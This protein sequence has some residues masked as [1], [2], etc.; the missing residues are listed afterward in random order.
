MTSAQQAA[1]LRSLLPTG[2]GSA[3]LRA[4]IAEDIRSRSVF[5]ARTTSAVYLSGVAEV[6]AKMANGDMDLATARWN[7]MQLLD[8]LGYTPEGGFPE[9]EE[10][11]PGPV[12]PAVAGSLQDLRSSRRLD[13]LLQTQ[14]DL[15]RG[16]GQQ[17]RGM[18]ST[19]MRLYP[20]WEL[21]RGI[22]VQQ[23]RQWG[24][25]HDGTPPKHLNQV[26]PRP[27][28]I[29]AGGKPH[30]SGRLIAFKG[31][32]IWGELGSS[33]N[34]DDALDVD[35]PP[36]AFNSG[37]RWLPVSA[38]EVRELGITGP[39][40]ETA[41]EWIAK[42]PRTMADVPGESPAATT[43]PSGIPAPQGSVKP[44]PE[45]LRKELTNKGDIVIVQDT[46]ARAE[47]EE[48]IRARIAAR[49]AARDAERQR[50]LET[51]IRRGTTP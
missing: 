20:A 16:R 26:D 6:V 35:F 49:R 33:G 25:I 19:A 43:P 5:S 47:D 31:D 36:F 30:P 18:D 41:E 34:F 37:M 40:G 22:T 8:A 10:D 46:A 24:G 23:P 27:R 15:V 38:R 28:W 7:L 42:K 45:D 2:L 21:W 44:V 39:D 11:A 3:D 29:I 1:L 32:P 4:L 14:L 12:P 17:I 51:A 9:M 50:D 48:A 13:L